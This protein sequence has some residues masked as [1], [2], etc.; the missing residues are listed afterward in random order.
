MSALVLLLLLHPAG[1]SRRAVS[2]RDAELAAKSAVAPLSLSRTWEQVCR[3]LPMNLGGGER[4]KNFA[5]QPPLLKLLLKC[6]VNNEE[7][8]TYVEA[9]LKDESNER[10]AGWSGED[11]GLGKSIGTRVLERGVHMDEFLIESFPGD[12]MDAPTFFVDLGE[13][14]SG[15]HLDKDGIDQERVKTLSGL[16]KYFDSTEGASD[17]DFE[18]FFLI[19]RLTSAGP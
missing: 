1:A 18:R 6:A 10:V 19:L 8:F 12:E 5:T 9:V 16:R 14:L 17:S 11:G 2:S 3:R 15:D 13:P 7:R 4:G